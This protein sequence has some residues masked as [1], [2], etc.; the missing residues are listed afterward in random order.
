MIDAAAT[1]HPG[2]LVMIPN[3]EIHTLDRLFDDYGAKRLWVTEI[4]EKWH[5]LNLVNVDPGGKDPQHA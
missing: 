5:E 2:D 1:F 3:G 4:G